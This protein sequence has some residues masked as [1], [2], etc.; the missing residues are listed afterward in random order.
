MLNIS[1]SV[2]IKYYH[3]C[4]LCVRGRGMRKDTGWFQTLA[5][6][7]IFVDE[8]LRSEMWF[9]FPPVVIFVMFKTT[10]ANK[11]KK[12]KIKKLPMLARFCR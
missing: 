11:L 5:L 6:M 9:K 4:V 10:A 1:L 8:K 12:N 2:D 3:W 7:S